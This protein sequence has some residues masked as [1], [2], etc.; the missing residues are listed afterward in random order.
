MKRHGHLWENVV[1]FESLLRAAEQARKGKRFRPAV[2]SFHFNL[3]HEL[4]SLHEELSAKT[5]RPGAYRTFFIHEPKARQISAAPYRDRVLHHALVN[6]LEPIFERTFIHDSYACRKGKGT[7]AA[8]VPQRHAGEGMMFGADGVEQGADPAVG[9]VLVGVTDKQVELVGRQ[10][11][12]GEDAQHGRADGPAGAAAAGAD[13]ALG[14]PAIFRLGLDRGGGRGEQ[15]RVEQ[16]DGVGGVG[17]G[18]LRPVD[19]AQMAAPLGRD[20]EVAGP[21][22]LLVAEPRIFWMS[23]VVSLPPQQG[24]LVDMRQHRW[25]VIE[26]AKSILPAISARPLP[27]SQCLVALSSIEDFQDAE[28]CTRVHV[29]RPR[30]QGK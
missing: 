12:Q 26:V 19:V 21:L 22:E 4:W 2:A 10:S 20:A 14:Q 13:V 29:F 7:H 15:F 16:L 30:R 23:S 24:Q 27:Q 5:Y 1:S 11:G 25:V 9:V 8:V 17:L 18:A 28:L 3:E 6:V